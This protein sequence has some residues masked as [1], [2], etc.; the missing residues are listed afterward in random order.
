MKRALSMLLPLLVACRSTPTQSP[1]PP[2]PPLLVDVPPFETSPRDASSPRDDAAPDV[3]QTAT[4]RDAGPATL[5]SAVAYTDDV[6][7]RELLEDPQWAF[8]TNNGEEDSHS[9]HGEIRPQSCE[10]NPCHTGLGQRCR[11]TCERACLTGDRGCR[12][13][14]VTCLAACHDDACRLACAQTEARCLED[15]L[16]AKDRCLTAVCGPRQAACEEAQQRRFRNGPCRAACQRC[17]SR[18]EGRDNMGD[19]YRACFRRTP[20]CEPDQQSICIM[21]GPNYGAAPEA[22]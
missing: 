21:I 5:S 3:T 17:A 15:A 8:P 16:A 9:C 7:A 12:T 19:C 1:R 4:P 10:P 20:G 14:A 2:L 6:V 13:T 18:C 11:D 22:Q